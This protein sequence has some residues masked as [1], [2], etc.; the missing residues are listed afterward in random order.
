MRLRSSLFWGIVLIMLAFFLLARQA[1]W[2]SGDIFGYFWPA[3][4]ILFGIWLLIGALSR[5][6]KGE[7][8][9]LSI[10]LENAA[11]ARIKFEH[12]AG[13][14][15]IHG[16]AAAAEVLSGVF[17]T[18]MDYRSRLEGSALDVKL[19]HASQMWAWYPGQSL[20]WDVSLNRDIPLSLKIDSGASATVLD[21]TDL[22][23]VDVDIDTGASSTDISLPASAGNTRVDIDSGAAS[24]KVKV[25]AG[26]AARIRIKS[27]MSGIHVDTNRFTHIDGGVYQS[28]DYATAANRA[29][30]SIDSGVGSIDIN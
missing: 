25:P 23:V 30:I 3:V 9:N 17:G 11:S 10:P 2:L 22:K 12:G 16:G 21:L 19:R 26:V 28:N 15:N 4:A 1:G 7:A 24:V 20:D 29:D 6:P 14:L 5:G 13:K 27:G 8:Y 18:E